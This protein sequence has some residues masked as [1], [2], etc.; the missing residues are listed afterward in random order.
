MNI[1][2]AAIILSN[3]HLDHALDQQ[4]PCTAA[5]QR[6]REQGP[7]ASRVSKIPVMAGLEGQCL[8]APVG[9]RNIL[10]RHLRTIDKAEKHRIGFDNT[11]FRTTSRNGVRIPGSRPGD[12][13]MSWP[14]RNLRR[15]GRRQKILGQGGWSFQSQE[16]WVMPGRHPA[17]GCACHRYADR[18]RH[19]TLHHL[20]HD[21]RWTDSDERDGR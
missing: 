4:G 20:D 8:P 6:H 17:R 16:G 10:S 9:Y 1:Q 2:K 11:K 7:C 18:L 5:G 12:G 3:S 14:W 21:A 13:R 19:R 15:P